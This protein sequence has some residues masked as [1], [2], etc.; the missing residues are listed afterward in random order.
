M[1]DLPNQ[2]RAGLIHWLQ[3]R[4]LIICEKGEVAMLW[5]PDLSLLLRTIPSVS[6]PSPCCLLC[7]VKI[8]RGICP[9]LWRQADVKASHRQALEHEC[10][11]GSCSWAPALD[12]LLCLAEGCPGLCNGNGRCTLDLNGWHCVCQLGWRGAGCDTSMETACGDSKDND[13]GRDLASV[14]PGQVQ[15]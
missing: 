8:L 1:E 4:I 3:L 6:L 14:G 2:A 9:Q 10:R 11:G 7:K 5:V 12:S 13:G 15:G